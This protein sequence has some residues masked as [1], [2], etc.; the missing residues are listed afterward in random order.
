MTNGA[1]RSQGP[2]TIDIVIHL[3][4]LPAS[5]WSGDD[6]ARPL[7]D[8]GRTQGERIAEELTASGGPIDAVFSS[9]IARCTQSLEALARRLDKPI[10]V[11]PGFTTMAHLGKAFTPR[12][13]YGA[14]PG[15]PGPDPAVIV[16]ST[17]AFEKSLAEVRA[18]VPSGRVV[19]CLPGDIFPRHL[20]YLAAKHDLQLPARVDRK[21]AVYTIVYEGDEVRISSRD[22]TADFPNDDA[23]IAELRS[24]RS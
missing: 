4:A 17:G 11:S 6:E 7:T 15:R 1:Q 13:G 20:V 2:L 10:R 21:G 16:H 19:I 18:A 9:P 5:E 23:K 22:A 12:E 3:D 14:A 24:R 8:L